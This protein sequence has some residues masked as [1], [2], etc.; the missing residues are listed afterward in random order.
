VIVT[1]CYI[2]AS[3]FVFANDGEQIKQ[4]IVNLR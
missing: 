2:A 4:I 3:L 1:F